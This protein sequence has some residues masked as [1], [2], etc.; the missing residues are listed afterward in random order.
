MDLATQAKIE[1]AESPAETPP[2]GARTPAGDL[3][4]DF[5]G[6]S[7]IQQSNSADFAETRIPDSDPRGGLMKFLHP[8]GSRPLDGYTIKR[9]IGRG[10]F[11]E[12]YY[13]TS[14]GG[15]EV[16]IKLVQRSLEVELR[17]VRQCMNLKHPNLVELYDVKEGTS[18]DSWVV[19]EYI[20]GETLEEVLARHPQGL[21][22]EE[23]LTWLQGILAGTG[24][25]HSQGIVHR[26]LKPGNV[27]REGQS[28]KIGDYGLSKFISASRRSGHTETIGTVHYMAPE[29]GS[30]RY[31]QELDIYAVGV[32]FHE[33]LTGRPPFEG[34]S[35]TEILMKHL[36][37]QP[38]LTKVPRRW[39]S[40]VSQC[41][42]KDPDKRF[43]SAEEM[44]QAVNSA[45]LLEEVGGHETLAQPEALA[46]P[47]VQPRPDPSDVRGVRTRPAEPARSV[48]QAAA[49]GGAGYLSHQRDQPEK[50]REPIAAFIGHTWKNLSEEPVALTV[51]IIAAVISFLVLP[52]LWLTAAWL[53]AVY[54]IA[55]KVIQALSGSSSSHQEPLPA[56]NPHQPHAY[57]QKTD[58]PQADR[59]RADRQPTDRQPTDWQQAYAQRKKAYAGGSPAQYPAAYHE[60]APK[61][62]R[63]RRKV[64]KRFYPVELPPKT[65]KQVWGEW[66]ASLFSSAAWVGALAALT[67]VAWMTAGGPKFGGPEFFTLAIVGTLGSWLIL[68]AEKRWEKKPG[69]ELYRR[70]LLGLGGLAIG[71]VAYL[72]DRVLFG[73]LGA[74]PATLAT[75]D[76]L[77]SPSMWR[78]WLTSRPL[79]DYLAY[80]GTLLFLMR[81][82]LQAD[83]LRKTRFSLWTVCFAALWGA[84]LQQLWPGVGPWGLLWGSIFSIAVQLSAPHQRAVAVRWSREKYEAAL[85]D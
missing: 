81:W 26:D 58:R 61:H 39:R 40:I 64:S 52:W 11:G 66:L 49:Y 22:E 85:S 13:A 25:L 17:G 18:G 28:I 65:S 47:A 31:G 51:F 27:F 1:T 35:P 55:F 82:W 3:C 15:K 4:D 9:G 75:A 71:G 63:V 34:E 24:Y 8:S 43:R 7:G 77:T 68:T 84:I 21:P 42:D 37:A 62:T 10:G 57:Q 56:R 32:I 41:L 76:Q 54:Y 5:D 67:G 48:H 20:C 6:D 60:A 23:A 29:I 80:F 12:V 44:Q 73:G 36:T 79:L 59:L 30:G 50:S 2:A 53:Y 33:M 70:F 38:D 69:D 19:M 45:V 16:A 14:D 83:P 46:K 74:G 78:I 72:T